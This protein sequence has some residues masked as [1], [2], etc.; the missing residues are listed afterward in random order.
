MFNFVEGEVWGIQLPSPKGMQSIR[1]RVVGQNPF[2]LAFIDDF[3]EAQGIQFLSGAVPFMARRLMTVE[4]A[5]AESA[6]RT[7]AAGVVLDEMKNVQ[8]ETSIVLP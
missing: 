8:K 1:V 2:G 3:D 5:Q 6:R 4:E 7:K